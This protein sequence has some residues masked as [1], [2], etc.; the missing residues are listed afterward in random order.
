MIFKLDYQN[1]EKDLNGRKKVINNKMIPK[2]SIIER[3]PLQIIIKNDLS[4]HSENK[5]N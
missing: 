5:E 1:L 2:I 3:E 4:S